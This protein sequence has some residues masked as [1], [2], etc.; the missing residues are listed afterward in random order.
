MIA[1]SCH[2]CSGASPTSSSAKNPPARQIGQWKRDHDRKS[3]NP[4]L[5]QSP[6]PNPQ[7]PQGQA[8]QILRQ[9]NGA[10][11]QQAESPAG[12]PKDIVPLQAI[13]NPDADK[14]GNAVGP[15]IGH[16]VEQQPIQR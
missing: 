3:R 11:P 4:Y 14:P 10:A 9:I 13:R 15:G 12:L 6:A 1:S 16:E 5:Q 7:A 8:Q 2:S